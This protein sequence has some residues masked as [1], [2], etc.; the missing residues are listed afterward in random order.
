MGINPKQ[1]YGDKKVALQLVPA[2]LD[3]AAAKGLKEGAVKYGAFNW[4]ENDVEVM[5]YVGAIK[6]HL[7]AWVDGEEIDPDSIHGKHH[8]DGVAASLAILLD[9]MA[10]GF[11]VD[12]RPPAGPG[13]RLVLPPK[14]QEEQLAAKRVAEGAFDVVQK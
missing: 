6:R 4:R 2:A 3:V 9:A 7:A 12:N 10:G 5:T 11:A 1:A 8:L 14:T 13:P